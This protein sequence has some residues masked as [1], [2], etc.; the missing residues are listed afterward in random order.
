MKTYKTEQGYYL[1]EMRHRG[2]LLL[3]EGEDWSD[4]K[5]GIGGLIG[6]RDV[7]LA[8]QHSKTNETSNIKFG[9]L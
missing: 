3:S 8:R 1:T 5:T 6:R 4:S 2:R 9:S 7:D